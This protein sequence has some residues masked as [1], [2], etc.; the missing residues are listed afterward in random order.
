[1][2]GREIPTLKSTLAMVGTGNAST[3]A[4]NNV[5]KSNFFIL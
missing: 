5:P 2:G 3:N 4:K 1:M